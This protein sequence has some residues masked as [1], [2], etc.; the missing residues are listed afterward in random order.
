LT[1]EVRVRVK[2]E[3]IPLTLALSH[4]GREGKREAVSPR[5]ENSF[6]SSPLTGG[7][8]GRH[9]ARIYSRWDMGNGRG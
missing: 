7:R 9:P 2:P 6:F 5:R 3:S 4:Q 1:G 8:V